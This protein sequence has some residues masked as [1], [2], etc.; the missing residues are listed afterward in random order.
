MAQSIVRKRWLVLPGPAWSC[1]VLPASPRFSVFPP[2][3]GL[4]AG[5]G[6]AG[7]ACGGLGVR[8]AGRG[9]GLAAVGAAGRLAFLAIS[10]QV[11]GVLSTDR[12]ELDQIRSVKRMAG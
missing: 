2:R 6:C 4:L 8:A 9:A 7:P 11:H 5:G 10:R 3:P 12:L 1:Q